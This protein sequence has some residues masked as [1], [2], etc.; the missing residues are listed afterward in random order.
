MTE[1]LDSWEQIGIGMI[2]VTILSVIFSII[3]NF[4]AFFTLMVKKVCGM[5]YSC[6]KAPQRRPDI[7][8]EAKEEPIE[9]IKPATEF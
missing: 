1:N 9:V 5:D 4:W 2:V 6:Y 7:V 8:E 3:V